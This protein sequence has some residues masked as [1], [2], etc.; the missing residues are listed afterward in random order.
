MP[1]TSYSVDE[2]G[3]ALLRLEREKTVGREVRN[4]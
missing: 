2:R 4:G 3:I 1:L